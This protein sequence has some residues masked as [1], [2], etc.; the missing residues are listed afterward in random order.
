MASI[1]KSQIGTG[2]VGG[3]SLPQTWEDQIP[4]DI[5]ALS[6]IH[7]GAQMKGEI[8]SS[9]RL[10]SI[11]SSTV[12]NAE[13]YIHYTA[14]AGHSH[15][16][17]PGIANNPLGYDPAKG[18]ALRF[19]GDTHSTI[20]IAC[21]HTKVDRMQF[22]NTATSSLAGGA[23]NVFGTT[24]TFVDIN[25]CICESSSKN[26]SIGTVLVRNASCKVRNTV[27]I[28]KGV[29]V[30]G[31]TAMNLNEGAQAI[32]CV[33]LAIGCTVN[34]ALVMS[35]TGGVVKNCYIGGG[36]LGAHNNGWGA[37][38]FSGCFSD[39][40]ATGCVVATAVDSFESVALATIDLRTKTGS[41]LRGG[42][43]IDNVNAAYDIYGQPRP[44]S[45]NPDSGAWQYVV[46]DTVGPNLTEQ[47]AISTGSTTYS[48]SVRTNEAGGSL[49]ALVSINAVETAVTTKANGTPYGVAAAGALS[50][51]GAGLTP[52]TTYYLHFVHTDSSGNDSARV[53]TASFTT[54]AAGDST[55]PVLSE[56]LF[57]E[58]GSTTAAGTV[59]TSEAG[60]LLYKYISTNV[61]ETGP[62]VKGANKTQ[63]V[64][65]AGVQNVSF[66]GLT[67]DVAYYV[68]LLHRDAAGNDSNVS[69]SAEINTF[70]IS[71]AGTLTTKPFKNGERQVLASLANLNVAV[72]TLPSLSYVGSVSGETTG[73]DGTNSVS[74]AGVNSGVPY[75]HITT[76]AAGTV[77]GAEIIVAT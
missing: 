25:Q 31:A 1:V 35:T 57:D 43:V 38:S 62:T 52:S 2:Q 53:T 40:S 65:S 45:S 75:A 41:L 76:N 11:G 7:V 36:T 54:S 58:T 74:M 17:D 72:L 51:S 26:T 16:D 37:G 9:T 39:V 50:V 28:L 73:V 18:A 69:T 29:T 20:T 56:P 6:Q 48:G 21:A 42:G 61:T 63:P 14:E 30:A 77:I 13:C 46:V 3:F 8:A 33:I 59:I 27:S 12:T 15:V 66:T 71:T 55:P 10:L 67:P 47:T 68:H 70:P 24:A 44:Q 22:S 19:T 4:A 60:G 34:Y 32:N 23:I 64:A 5:V 49:R